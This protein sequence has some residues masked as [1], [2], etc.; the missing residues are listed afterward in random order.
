M[1]SSDVGDERAIEEAIDNMLGMCGNEGQETLISRNSDAF[2]QWSAEALEVAGAF[3]S[4]EDMMSSLDVNTAD[5][6]YQG[7]QEIWRMGYQ[8]MV[9]QSRFHDSIDEQGEGTGE[10]VAF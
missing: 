3:G 8:A 9:N 10:N 7:T 1:V 5:H 4:F 6:S 2:Y